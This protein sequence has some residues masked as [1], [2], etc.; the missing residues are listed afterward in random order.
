M[1]ALANGVLG[2][3]MTDLTVKEELLE[4][5]GYRYHFDR[6]IYINRAARRAFSL[7]FVEDHSQ[8]EIQKLLETPATN[9]WVFHFNKQLSDRVKR[10][11]AE[12]L[13]PSVRCCGL[14][15][16]DVGDAGGSLEDGLTLLLAFHEPDRSQ[17]KRPQLT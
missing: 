7:E 10:E 13:E 11:L 14:L 17:S 9:D 15:A 1:I 5:S 3:R 12:V 6:M 2:T 16:D 4:N 8:Q